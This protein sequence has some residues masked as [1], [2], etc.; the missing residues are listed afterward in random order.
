MMTRRQNLAITLVLAATA[1]A[2]GAQSGGDYAITRSLI[3]GGG[4]TALSTD[5]RMAASAG[6]GLTGAANGGD[7][8]LRG[9]F[10]QAPVGTS[11]ADA[12]YADG[13]EARTR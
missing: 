9:G 6:Q 11:T 1:A 4:G 13:F 10:W 5:F 8:S 7:Y 12:I 3:A 2:A